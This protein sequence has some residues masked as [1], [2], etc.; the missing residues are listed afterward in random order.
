[1]KTTVEKGISLWYEMHR[2]ERLGDLIFSIWALLPST[3]YPFLCSVFSA[4]S[5]MVSVTINKVI[6]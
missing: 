5:I 2:I 4:C 6:C 3:N 1:M